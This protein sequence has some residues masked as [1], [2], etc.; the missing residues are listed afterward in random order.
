M[1]FT[2]YLQYWP[3]AFIITWSLLGLYR[4][5]VTMDS[6]EPQ[7]MNWK[8]Y[9]TLAV[10]FWAFWSA[11]IVKFT[12]PFIILVFLLTVGAALVCRDRN[13]PREPR[14]MFAILFVYLLLHSLYYWAGF[15][16][17]FLNK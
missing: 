8:N 12:W 7:K 16:N 17:I 4:N 10:S 9:I 13:K 2:D 5:I 14:S 15:Y 11:G 1:T 6:T 3:Q